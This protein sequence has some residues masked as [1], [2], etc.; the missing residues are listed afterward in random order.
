M[1]GSEEGVYRRQLPQTSGI[2]E[3]MFHQQDKGLLLYHYHRTDETASG[4]L[5]EYKYYDMDDV[6]KS[7][8]DCVEKL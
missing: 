5:A 4:R 6:I 7:A 1:A 2:P 8:F 3:R